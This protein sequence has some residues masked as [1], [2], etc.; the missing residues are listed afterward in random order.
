MSTLTA[1]LRDVRKNQKR[2]DFTDLL[3]L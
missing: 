1:G 3:L 2:S